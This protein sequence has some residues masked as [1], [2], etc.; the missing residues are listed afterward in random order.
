METASASEREGKDIEV[1]ASTNPEGAD[2]DNE[3]GDYG[4]WMLMKRKKHAAK[5]WATCS[6]PLKSNPKQILAL[7]A[8]DLGRLRRLT[9]EAKPP[10]KPPAISPDRKRKSRRFDNTGL[11]EPTCSTSLDSMATVTTNFAL[12]KANHRNLGLKINDTLGCNTLQKATSPKTEAPT[13]N[14]K[15]FNKSKSKPGGAFA[16]HG[17]QH[18]KVVGNKPTQ[19]SHAAVPIFH[20]ANSSIPHNDLGV[21]RLG[22]T[23]SMEQHFSSHSKEPAPRVPSTDRPDMAR[24]GLPL[25]EIPN[26]H[27]NMAE[28]KIMGWRALS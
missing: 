16:S 24:L 19:E 21:V 26:E 27:P 28:G 15:N 9:Q 1:D 23:V 18:T 11:T 20:S 7:N 25:L 22:T 5:N 14:Q 8:K 12:I 17:R 4:P 13:P 2:A 10:T 3:K 6:H